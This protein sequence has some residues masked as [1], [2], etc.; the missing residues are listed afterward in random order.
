MLCRSYS[1]FLSFMFDK[2]KSS[3]QAWLVIRIVL[4]VVLVIHGYGKVFGGVPM[5][6]GMLTK[7]GVPMPGLMA[8]VVALLELVGGLMIALGLYTRYVAG[9]LIVQFAVI[10]VIVKKFGFPASDTDLLIFGSSI[11]LALVGAGA[12]SLDA[13]MASKKASKPEVT[14]AP[15]TPPP[16]AS[17]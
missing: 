9:L 15:M 5:F 2:S 8:W 10:L 16:S 7:M 3:D 4:A 11:A 13:K 17:V 6:T 1:L 14:A 12:L